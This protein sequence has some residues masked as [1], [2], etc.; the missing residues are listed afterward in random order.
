MKNKVGQIAIF[1]IIAIVIVAVIA[2][3]FLIRSEI[4]IIPTVRK[5]SSPEPFIE[6]CARTAA[7]DTL[8]VMLPQG[9]FVDPKNYKLYQDTKITYLCQ[10]KGFFEPCINQHPVLM[11]EVREELKGEIINDV[12]NCFLSMKEDLESKG[13]EVSLGELNLSVDLGPN[14]V[15]LNIERTMDI[16]EKGEAIA[17]NDFSSEFL[18]PTYDLVNVANEIASQEVKYCYFEYAGYMILHPDIKI[19]KT[20]LSDST[21]IYSVSDRDSGHELNFAIRSCAIPEGI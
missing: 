8:S 21:K 16:K 4:D 5:T 18:H 1:V 7:R 14:R 12:D 3:V 13:A 20:A 11:N 10:N 17:L 2:F 9:G 6:S 15:R 19:T